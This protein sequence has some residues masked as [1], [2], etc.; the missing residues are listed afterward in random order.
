MFEAVSP[1]LEL[2][3]IFFACGGL[4]A[5]YGG[6]LTFI[7]SLNVKIKFF[8]C[9]SPLS[10]YLNNQNYIQVVKA[11]IYTKIT[12]SLDVFGLWQSFFV[13]DRLLACYDGKLTLIHS[14]NV[15][16]TKFCL[17]QPSLHVIDVFY[18]DNLI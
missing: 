5:C 3:Q 4:L 6:I 14:L 9:S 11:M 15:K 17:Q 12:Q 7:H 16:G 8:A 18:V 2:W 10:L 13:W 1:S